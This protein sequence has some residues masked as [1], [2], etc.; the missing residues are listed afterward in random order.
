MN[1]VPNVKNPGSH[2]SHH[3]PDGTYEKIRKD[4]L[5]NPGFT[6]AEFRAAAYLAT[7]PAGWVVRT[8]HIAVQLHWPV[9]RARLALRGLRAKGY[10]RLSDAERKDGRFSSRDSTLIKQLVVV[11]RG[12]HIPAGSEQGKEDVSAGQHQRVNNQRVAATPLEI[13]VVA[14][15]NSEK[16]ERPREDD[17]SL[18]LLS[19]MDDLPEQQ[20]QRAEL[21]HDESQDL[22][23]PPRRLL[24]RCPPR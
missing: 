16:P 1:T 23:P 2:K 13:T 24:L 21:R 19:L 6:D 18:D 17:A 20:Q 4:F 9:E 22:P 8:K 12:E 3:S 11:T 7:K 14:S 10:L 5:E 15:D